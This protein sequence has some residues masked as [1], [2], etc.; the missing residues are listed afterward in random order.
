MNLIQI[1][2]LFFSFLTDN[3]AQEFVWIHETFAKTTPILTLFTTK[4]EVFLPCVAKYRRVHKS[5]FLKHMK[6]GQKICGKNPEKCLTGYV[7]KILDLMLRGN[8]VDVCASTDS[9]DS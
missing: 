5:S 2:I 1:F 7:L 3:E 8:F 4:N 9:P 6:K